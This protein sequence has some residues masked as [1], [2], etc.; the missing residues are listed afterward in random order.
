MAEAYAGSI[1]LEVD[2][3]EVE[4]IKLDAKESTGRKLVKT[5]NSQ[6]TAQGYAQGIAEYSLSI[7][8]AVPLEGGAID[9]AGIKDGKLTV[10]PLNQNDKRT[11]Y[12]G[13]F[14]T[15]VG[16]SYTVDN[17]AVQDIQMQALRK[18]VE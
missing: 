5:M 14:T 4:V 6:G 2:G 3:R 13:C 12:L 8:A 15:E 17:E 11:S 18:V 16:Q 9:W 10:Y 1:V 7:S